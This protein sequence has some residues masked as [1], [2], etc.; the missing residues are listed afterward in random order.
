[1]SESLLKNL[2]EKLANLDCTQ[3]NIEKTS[4]EFLNV[5][6]KDETLGEDLVKLWKF[7]CLKKTNKLPYIYLANDIIQNS[8]FKKMAFQEIFFKHLLEVFP[9][10]YHVVTDK[11]KKEIHK[12][13]DIWAERNV[14]GSEKLNS[15]RNLLTPKI[16][17]FENLN[18]P[19]F[20]N[21][22]LNK[23]IK[24][25]PKIVEFGANLESLKFYENKNDNKIK[26]MFSENSDWNENLN[27]N[28][29]SFEDI[30]N[31]DF[32]IEHNKRGQVL[33]LCADAIKKQNQIFF[34]HVFYLQEIDKMLEKIEKNK[35]P[36]KIINDQ[37]MK[38]EI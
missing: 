21:L 11:V 7:F 2:E 34:K 16:S 24:I 31:V 9:L 20:P 4:E 26:K 1:M 36:R 30:N 25:S 17:I 38:M 3:A 8:A 32:T 37:E 14:Y 22:I 5:N 18:N 12:L 28:Q 35:Q 23:K 27:R 15:L 6:R 29:S 33:G 19:L 10:L 13:I